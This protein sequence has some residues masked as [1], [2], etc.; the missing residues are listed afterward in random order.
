MSNAPVPAP[1]PA[2]SSSRGSATYFF[3]RGVAITL[4]PVLTLLILLWAGN[5][6]NTYVIQPVNSVV[7]FALASWKNDIRTRDQLVIPPAG[8]PSLPEWNRNYLVTESLADEY[9]DVRE[10]DKLV[11][12]DEIKRS[13]YVPMARG[14]DPGKF[15]PLIDYELVFKDLRPVPPPTTA[16]GLYMEIVSVRDFRSQWL[17]S[18]LSLSLAIIAMYFLGRFVTARI[19]TWFV[20]KIEGMLT[21]VPLVR[22]VYST[23]KQVTDFVLS[24]REVEF[25]RVVALEYPRAGSWTLGFVTGEGML[26]CA[27]QVGEPMVTVLVPTS[28][29]PAG[30]FTVMV[31]RSSVIDLNLTIDQ[32]VQFVVSCGVLIPPHQKAS[33]GPLEQE[34]QKRL[35]ASG[36]EAA[37]AATRTNGNNGP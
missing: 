31:T 24:D 27:A 22:N 35:S 34:V 18:A 14:A 30:G 26:D 13:V 21:R 15:V 2:P 32:A 28:P 11:L 20:R 1:A 8:F 4:P 5:G 36:L 25:Q 23:V 29:V 33:A 16:I 6:F 3:L 37:G 12:T 17:L 10:S 9:R 7:R 19:G